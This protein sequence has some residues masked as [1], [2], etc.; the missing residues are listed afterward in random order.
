M[1][2]SAV[3]MTMSDVYLSLLYHYPFFIVML[4]VPAFSGGVW[5]L[6]MGQRT[7]KSGTPAIIQDSMV[8]CQVAVVTL[9][10]F[11][12]TFFL[13]TVGFSAV[14]TPAPSHTP[15]RVEQ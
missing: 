3:V 2:F 6:S 9:M 1:V 14:G 10:D 15:F 8:P 4:G 12:E 11:P 13:G 7:R 5:L